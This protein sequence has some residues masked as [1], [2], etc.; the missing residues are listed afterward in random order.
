MNATP[1][2]F[3]PGL[4]LKRPDVGEREDVSERHQAKI[5]SYGLLYVEVRQQSTGFASNT[6]RSQM[7]ILVVWTTEFREAS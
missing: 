7:I 4:Q 5:N 2:R 3:K 6:G 1:T